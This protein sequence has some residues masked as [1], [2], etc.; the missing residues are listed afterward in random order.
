MYRKPRLEDVEQTQTYADTVSAFAANFEMQLGI[1]GKVH[2]GCGVTRDLRLLAVTGAFGLRVEN[3][4]FPTWGVAGGMAGGISKV[5]MNFG[6][7]DEREIRPFSDD[8]VW[9]RGDMVRITLRVVEVG[10]LS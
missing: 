1:A 9:S 3:N 2:G 5:V 8:N 10:R 4:I 7:A 6:T